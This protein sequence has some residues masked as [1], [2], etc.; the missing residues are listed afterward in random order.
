MTILRVRDVNT[1]VRSD[2]DAL[3]I[4]A[5]DGTI[6]ESSSIFAPC[7]VWTEFRL[8]ERDTYKEIC[9]SQ[10]DRSGDSE[11]LEMVCSFSSAYFILTTVASFY[12][13]IS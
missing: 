12:M 7:C 10:I 13:I 1:V 2:K 11:A 8:I 5:A 9:A 3:W 6:G 4:A